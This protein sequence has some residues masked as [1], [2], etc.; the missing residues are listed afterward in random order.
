MGNL[1]RGEL[2]TGFQDGLA[3]R[4]PLESADPEDLHPHRLSMAQ[5]LLRPL[6]CVT[7]S[8]AGAAAVSGAAFVLFKLQL[9]T[10]HISMEEPSLRMV[11]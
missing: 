4:D 6:S 3:I 9:F 7:C 8:L 11:Q 2:G 1:L 5:V 10:M